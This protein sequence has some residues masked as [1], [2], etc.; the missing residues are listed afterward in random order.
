MHY[1]HYTSNMHDQYHRT[2]NTPDIDSTK[3]HVVNYQGVLAILQSVKH[4]GMEKSHLVDI[5]R[6]RMPSTAFSR[7]KQSSIHVARTGE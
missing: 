3:Q 1:L 4:S 5:A 2:S 6:C 7:Q